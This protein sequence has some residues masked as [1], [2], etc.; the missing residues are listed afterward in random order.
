MSKVLKFE[1]T[2]AAMDRL[3]AAGKR[4]VQCHGTFDLVHPGHVIHFEEARALGDVLVVTI[5]GEAHTN[6]GPG[7]PYFGDR[8]RLKMLG[9]LAA[10]DHV[11]VIPFSAAVEA[12]ECV[13]PHVYCKGKEYADPGADVTGHM[14]DDLE[15]VARVGGT[16][17]YV[18]SEIFSSTR[19][20]NQHFDPYPDSVKSFARVVAAETPPERMR[21]IVDSFAGLSVV[22]VGEIIFDRY[23]TVN[24]QGLS[25]KSQIM[26]GRY[27]GEDTQGGGALAILRHVRQFTSRVKIVSV[28]GGEAW[29]GDSLKAFLAPSEDEIL[30]V[31]GYVT[32]LKQRFVEPMIAG[33]EIAKLFSYNYMDDKPQPESVQAS[34]RER[35]AS[36]VAGADVV[37]VADFG[38]GLLSESVRDLLQEKSKF[39][40]LNCQTNSSNRGY[41]I[42]NRQYQ[43]ADSFSLDETEIR[44]ASAKKHIDYR[45]TLEQLRVDLK[46]NYAWLTRGQF[47]TIGLTKAG[48]SCACPPFERNVVDPVGA[49]DAFCTL[50]AL[51]AVRQI[52]IATATFLSQ[53]AGAQAVRIVG[54][55][56][57]IRKDRILAAGTAMLKI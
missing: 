25:S 24:I 41:N 17:H 29:V 9:A 18:G 14:Q 34:F 52:P 13:R 3:R 4:I 35:I 27:L 51:S 53:L 1:E 12:I 6:K 10:V 28:V 38:H 45:A 48:A 31:P 56:E 15:A 23:T 30:R 16:V 50:A 26:S 7:R 54:N 47:E 57:S 2:P 46:S 43:R 11:V 40:A 20:L 21:E 36:A 42:I 22:V 55:A 37:I 44:L 8:L 49:G 32:I 33:R 19:L 39:L 5:T